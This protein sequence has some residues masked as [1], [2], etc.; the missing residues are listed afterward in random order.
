MRTHVGT[1]R[2]DGPGSLGD[3]SAAQSGYPRL[4]RRCSRLG[5]P[6]RPQ[7]SRRRTTRDGTT[8]ARSHQAEPVRPSTQLQ[9][10]RRHRSDRHRPCARTPVSGQWARRRADRPPQH[11]SARLLPRSDGFALRWGYGT[12]SSFN[13]KANASISSRAHS[14]MLGHYRSSAT[15]GTFSSWTRRRFGV[16]E[17]I[18]LSSAR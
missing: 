18:S 8:G 3:C 10:L 12:R 16:N 1:A 13:Q 4:Q 7:Q 5:S 15:A 14:G 11:V 2:A 6:L 9:R 17:S